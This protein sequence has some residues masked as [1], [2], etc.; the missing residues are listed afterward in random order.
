MSTQLDLS[1]FGSP[2]WLDLPRPTF[3]TL[4]RN[5]NAEAVV[6]GSGIA[7]MK[8]ARCL[9]REGVDAVILEAGRA[10][11]GASSRN[12]GSINQGPNMSYPDCIRR[13]SRY[14]A[15]ELWQMGL[16]NH[17]LLKS[18]IDEYHIDCDY[19]V[20]GFTS[21][22]RRD[23]ADWH[24]RVE[25]YRRESDLLRE[26]GFDVTFLNE[27]QAEQVGGN[28]IYAGGMRY[29]SD[30]QFHSGKYAIGL[31]QGVTRLPHVQLFETARVHEI[32]STGT[33]TVVKTENHTIETERVFL[34][35]N[36]LVPQF[37][38]GLASALRA[39]RGQVF[40]TEPLAERPCQ[41]SF[42]TSLAWWR[43]IIERD[44][45][46]RL[47]FGGGREREEPDSLF[48]Q[49]TS[50]G[51]PNP[52]LEAEGFRPSL[53]HQRRLDEQFQLLFP[54]LAD[55]RI[56]HR[57]GGLQSFTAD[58]VPQ[59]GLLDTE[60]NIY[61]IA[62]FCGRGNCHSDVCAEHIVSKALGVESNVSNRFGFLIETMM[63]APRKSA[64][65]KPWQSEQSL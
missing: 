17:R 59:A 44:G 32:E 7:G 52:R 38:P 42:G 8:I 57:W 24:D 48:P 54:H 34:S 14:I 35:T 29:E 12:Q 11:D 13:H 50:D 55:V 1:H 26:D 4:D 2:Y 40:V 21:L 28:S 47:L 30:A 61:G 37:I 27:Q 49:F 16:E 45:R 10:C 51:G 43:E 65:W 5:L 31:V 25:A 19:Q 60:R 9:A 46:F 6:I 53:A 20:D 58:D 56:T 33:R 23:E 63:Q 15:R 3:A 62:G 41:G 22:A 64:D 39:E 18:Q 36:A